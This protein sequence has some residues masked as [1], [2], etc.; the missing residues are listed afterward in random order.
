MWG[1]WRYIGKCKG[2][3]NISK[4]ISDSDVELLSKIYW[5][6]YYNVGWLWHWVLN[7]CTMN[8]YKGLW[9]QKLTFP[10]RTVSSSAILSFLSTSK[11]SQATCA[12]KCKKLGWFPSLRIKRQH[13]A[14]FISSTL[15]L[16]LKNAV[17]GFHQLSAEGEVKVANDSTAGNLSFVSEKQA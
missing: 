12:V 13:F 17:L 15:E 16:H 1:V 5:F 8:I 3:F 2:D 7:F 11:P 4:I 9:S 10:L 14:D 6:E